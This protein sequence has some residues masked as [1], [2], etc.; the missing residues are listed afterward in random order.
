MSST[1]SLIY[2]YFSLISLSLSVEPSHFSCSSAVTH[3]PT[4]SSEWLAYVILPIRS[5]TSSLMIRTN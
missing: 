2:Y 4:P 5:V 1:C 3:T